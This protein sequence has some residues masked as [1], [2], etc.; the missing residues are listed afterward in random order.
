[1][2][3]EN[4]NVSSPAD[5]GMPPHPTTTE[6]RVEFADIGGR[7]TIVMTHG[8]IPADSPGAVGWAMAL[9]KLVAHV[10]THGATEGPGKS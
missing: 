2:C 3:D 5:M 1:M 4:G 10:K 6:V 7:T 9:D 8:G